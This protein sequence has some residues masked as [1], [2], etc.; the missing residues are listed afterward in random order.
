MIVSKG[1]MIVSKGPTLGN[2]FICEISQKLT[3]KILWMA[4]FFSTGVNTVDFKG[5]KNTE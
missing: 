5:F 4:T 2:K 3:M 1:P